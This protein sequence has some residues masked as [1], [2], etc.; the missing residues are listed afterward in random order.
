MRNRPHV[1]NI[2]I[3]EELQRAAPLYRKQVSSSKRYSELVC[4]NDNWYRAKDDSFDLRNNW[5]TVE[6]LMVVF[7]GDQDRSRFCVFLPLFL[8]LYFEADNSDCRIKLKLWGKDVAAIQ[9]VT[10]S[11]E[12]ETECSVFHHTQ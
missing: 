5:D 2:R 9:S 8:I 10:D 11:N 7:F 6:Q 3:E 4:R 12:K 1:V